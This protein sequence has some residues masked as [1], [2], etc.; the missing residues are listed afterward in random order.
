MYGVTVQKELKSQ[1]AQTGSQLLGMF[2]QRLVTVL[3]FQP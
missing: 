1:A 2:E 3:S